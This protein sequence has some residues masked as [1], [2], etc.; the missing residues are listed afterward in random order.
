MAAQ[1]QIQIPPASRQLLERLKAMP[2]R[3][4][5]IVAAGMKKQ[6]PFTVT[7][8]QQN[9]LTGLGPFP[10]EQHKLGVRSSRLRGSVI[11]SE[12]VITGEQVSTS[13]GSNVKYAAIHE[14]GGVIRI[15]ARTTQIGLRTDRRGNLL[16]QPLHRNLAVFAFKN[17]KLARRQTVTI[18]AHDIPMP[19][20]APFRTGIR[21]CLPDYAQAIATAFAQA[22]KS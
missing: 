5:Q 7:A 2:G 20:R 15:G 4:P 10:P 22:L 3:V 1:L 11:A 9:H 8:I 12:P 14:F 17:Q 19:E 6:D 13:I 18:P 21:E 16:R